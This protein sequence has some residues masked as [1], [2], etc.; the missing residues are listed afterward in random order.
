M[1][2]GIILV[3]AGILIA[4]FPPLLA[5]VVAAVLIFSGIFLIYLGYQFKKVN[6]NFGNP[7]I[8]FL[9]KL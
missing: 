1:V 2:L 5:W 7:F 6:R 4:I 9:F 8:D 3:L